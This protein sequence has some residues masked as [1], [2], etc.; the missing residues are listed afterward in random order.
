MDFRKKITAAKILILSLMIG[1]IVVTFLFVLNWKEK[2]YFGQELKPS[3]KLAYGKR[4]S[5][6]EY[7]GDKK[8]YAV[9]VDSFSIERARLGPFAIGPLRIAHL[10]KVV[11]D[12]YLDA[13]ESR[14]DK[15]KVEQKTGEGKIPGFGNGI[16]SNVE[17][18]LSLQIGKIRGI[19]FKDIS[20]NLWRDDKKILKISSDS[21]T[22]D[23]KTRDLIFAGHANM[24]GGENGELVSYRIRWNWKT[25]LFKV[26]DPYYLIKNGSKTEGRGIETDYLFK[27][28][29]YLTSPQ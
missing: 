28:I 2:G 27:K 9:S 6:V 16:L 1:I 22:I 17:K 15:N 5:F 7:H 24:D 14:L 10:S 11:I 19:E 29:T 26:T 18:N 25:S 3:S 13:I 8:V 23:R 12:L 20:I 21:A 4:I